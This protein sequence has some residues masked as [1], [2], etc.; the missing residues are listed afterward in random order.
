MASPDYRDP[1][2]H[3]QMDRFAARSARGQI[4]AT[5]DALL[6]DSTAPIAAHL[7]ADVPV[8]GTSELIAAIDGAA[9]AMLSLLGPRLASQP[10]AGWGPLP[11]ADVVCVD[12]SVASLPDGSWDVR[13]VEV[14]A[15]TSII[16]TSVILAA[17]HQ[18]M[19]PELSAQC[20]WDRAVAPDWASWKRAVRRHIAPTGGVVLEHLPYEQGTLFDLEATSLLWK[21]PLLDIRDMRRLGTELR[22]GKDWVHHCVNRVIAHET[23][24]IT[25]QQ[26]LLRGARATWHSH[27]GW[28]YQ[29]EKSTLSELA[30]PAAQRCAPAAQWR[31]LG[32]PASALVLKRL[33]SCGGKDVFLHVTEDNLDRLVD[34]HDWMVQPRYTPRT[35]LHASDGAP[36]H[37]EVRCMMALPTDSEPWVMARMARLSRGAKVSRECMT[38]GPGEGL[39]LLYDPPA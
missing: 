1:L 30:L 38:G 32:L 39:S 13:F 22:L 11:P 35:L 29:V 26:E 37:M 27:P 7:I 17:A 12:L 34:P 20:A 28:Y 36:V 8:V 3:A 10:G 16:A 33:F 9:R 6:P 23:G 15:F 2:L 31:D 4:A 14:Q 24:N 21:L 25:A 18:E 5:W 19:W